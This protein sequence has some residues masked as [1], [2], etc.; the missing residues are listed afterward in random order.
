M[1]LPA[2]TALASLGPTR[3][4]GPAWTAELYRDCG[5]DP[6]AADPPEIAVLFKPAFRAAWEVR[7]VPRRIGLRG[8]LRDWLLTDPVDPV[9]G[10]RWEEYGSIA[11]VLGL[12]GLGWPEF[13][14]RPGEETEVPEGAVLFL[15]GTRSGETVRWP[16]H[17]ALADLLGGRAIFGGGPD[18]E[19][20]VAEIA[21]PHPRLGAL[22]LGAF[23]ALCCRVQ[24]I[25]GN[26]SGLAHLACAARRAA[27][28]DPAA[29]HVI[30]GSTVP[31]RTGPQGAT[32][33]L[34]PR[35]PCAPC[36]AKRCEIGGAPCLELPAE[37]LW[38][39]LK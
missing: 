28:L 32:A 35:L 6:E 2:I 34:G 29:V 13:A 23:A 15:P 16:H 30:F 11:G 14:W 26:D 27:G 10:H 19:A 25:V 21:G 12:D 38:E 31:E 18:E 39:A 7:G 4:V 17:R 24:A 36:Y 33:W 37:R 3:V 20:L 1:A 8:D 9:S 5:L 22:S